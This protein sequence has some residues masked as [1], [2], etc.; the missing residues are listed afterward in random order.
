MRVESLRLAAAAHQWYRAFMAEPV[1]IPAALLMLAPEL[2][3]Q[4]L[5]L[6]VCPYFQVAL[7]RDCHVTTMGWP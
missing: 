6:V 2:R 4:L 5:V 7:P 1:A 3:P